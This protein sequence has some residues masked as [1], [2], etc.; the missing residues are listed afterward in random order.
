MCKENKDNFYNSAKS[1]ADVGLLQHPRW[2][3]LR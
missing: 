3:S 1:E 2:S